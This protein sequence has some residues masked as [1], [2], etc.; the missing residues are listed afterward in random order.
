ML[1]RA[2]GRKRRAL[3][4][5]SA[6][7]RSSAAVEWSLWLAR[8][9]A[10]RAREM[11]L[12]P[13]LAVRLFISVAPTGMLWVRKLCQLVLFSVLLLPGFL[14]VVAWYFLSPAVVRSVRYGRHQRNML[15][16]YLP[17]G[18]RAIELRQVGPRAAAEG[19]AVEDAGE[20]RPRPLVVFCPGGV[21]MIGYKAWGAL[22]ARTLMQAGFVVACVDYRNYPLGTVSQMEEDVTQ[23][24][25]WVLDNA[26]ELGADRARI[27]LVGQS[28]GAHLSALSLFRQAAL[29]RRCTQ[30]PDAASGTDAAADVANGPVAATASPSLAEIAELDEHTAGYPRWDPLELCAFVG[31]SGPYSLSAS[32]VAHFR[33]HGLHPSL[34]D[35]IMEKDLAR[36]CPVAVLEASGVRAEDMPPIAL[37]QGDADISVPMEQCNALGDAL[38]RFAGARAGEDLFLRIYRGETHTS[39]IIEGPMAGGRDVLTEDIVKATYGALWWGTELELDESAE[40]EVAS[41]LSAVEAK[42]LL[43]RFVV[44]AARAIAPF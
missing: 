35:L 29:V 33:A 10:A 8:E 31:V 43:P 6:R 34:L 25:R 36:N 38:E 23:A 4:A 19:V 27:S 7:V 11:L 40:A 41:A 1:A 32:L 5:L 30:A 12:L 13:V 18:A 28:A 37:L 17:Q 16:L 3:R 42:P 14:Q 21:W 44:S 22:L 20:A 24:V 2:P 9:A 15:D 39:P 26:D